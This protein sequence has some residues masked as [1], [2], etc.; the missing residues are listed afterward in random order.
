MI[1][2]HPAFPSQNPSPAALVLQKEAI[3][4]RN[5]S[6]QGHKGLR[7]KLHTKRGPKKGWRY[8]VGVRA[9]KVK[10][11]WHSVS[12]PFPGVPLARVA[13]AGVAVRVDGPPADPALDAGAGQ[14]GGELRV[15]LGVRLLHGLEVAAL[16]VPGAP[17]GS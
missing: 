11:V 5:H 2:V 9:A 4:S 12:L 10:A 14:P 6:W 17:D 1:G 7:D 13:G 3:S 8:S 15:R 16:V